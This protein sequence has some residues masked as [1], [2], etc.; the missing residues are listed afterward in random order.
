MLLG[1]AD[2]RQFAEDDMV[3]G[4]PVFDG[5]AAKRMVVGVEYISRFLVSSM[6]F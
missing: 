5:V 1:L 4:L 3:L 6:E 2:E